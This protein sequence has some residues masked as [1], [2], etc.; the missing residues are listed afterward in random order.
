VD[1]NILDYFI[2]DMQKK[3]EN[4]NFRTKPYNMSKLLLF[5]LLFT[6]LMFSQ[7]LHY[8][9]QCLPHQCTIVSLKSASGSPLKTSFNCQM[10]RGSNLHCSLQCKYIPHC[11]SHC[12]TKK[13]TSKTEQA[14]KQ[15]KTIKQKNM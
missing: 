1:R 4:I 15:N 14:M 6:T 7:I 12:N 8:N 3:K 5:V 9:F 2:Q 13:L 11:F 10:S